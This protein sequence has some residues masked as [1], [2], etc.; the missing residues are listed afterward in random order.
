MHGANEHLPISGLG[1]S[2]RRRQTKSNVSA[3]REPSRA[4][5]LF[6]NYQPHAHAL[7]WSDKSRNEAQRDERR[8]DRRQQ[9]RRLRWASLRER[10]QF[11]SRLRL[12]WRYRNGCDSSLG[13]ED[14]RFWAE[15]PLHFPTR[16]PE[17]GQRGR[18]LLVPKVY[19]HDGWCSTI[20]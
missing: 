8:H 12:R 19:R 15:H 14:G 17:A 11:L 4:P 18:L 20:P 5:E 6:K 16:D 2:S 1:I 13:A 10:P 3:N 9:H 7:R